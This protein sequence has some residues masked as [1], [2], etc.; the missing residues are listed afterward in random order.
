MKLT[1]HDCRDLGIID[2]V[3][4]EPPGGA[5]LD[6]EEAARQLRRMIVSELVNLQS[7]STKKMLKDRY[8]K[9]RNIGEYSSYF[10]AALTREVNALQNLVS[11]GARWITRRSAPTDPPPKPEKPD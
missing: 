2:T 5:H 7:T 1:A 11:S 9:Y 8:K 10:S 4:P 3:V 6:P